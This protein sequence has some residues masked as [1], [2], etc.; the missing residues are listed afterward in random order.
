MNTASRMETTGVINRIHISQETAKLLIAAK[1]GQWVVPQ[2]NRV[3]AK[4]K[5]EMVTYFLHPEDYFPT[6]EGGCGSETR[7]NT[8]KKET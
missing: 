3:M 5:G 6:S 4:G 1:K 8:D 7:A 2:E